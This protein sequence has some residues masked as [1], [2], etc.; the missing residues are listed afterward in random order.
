MERTLSIIKPS[1][2][3]DRHI[4]E[5]ISHFEKAEIEISAMRYTYLSK[6][7]AEE[8]Y[9]EHKERP[10]FNSL[11]KFMTSGPVILMVLSGDNIIERNRELMGATNPK[12]AKLGTIRQQFG[13][14]VEANAVHGSDSPESAKREV[15]F[16]FSD[17]DEQHLKAA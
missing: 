9:K 10:F 4:G 17:L 16:F 8:F 1:A 14:D 6:E 13:R 7:E 15:D 11:V 5:I 3:E 12:D 2:I